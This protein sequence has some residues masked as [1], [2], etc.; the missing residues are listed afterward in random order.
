MEDNKCDYYFE[1][2]RCLYQTF[3]LGDMRRHLSKEAKCEWKNPYIQEGVF[4]EKY[5]N[6]MSLEKKY[7]NAEAVKKE[8]EEKKKEETEE[9]EAHENHQD[10]HFCGKKFSRKTNLKRHLQTSCT[11]KKILEFVDLEKAK[12]EIHNVQNSI[13]TQNNIQTQNITNITQNISVNIDENALKNMLIPFFEKFDTSH[14][15][16]DKRRKLLFKTVYQDALREILK[17]ESNMNFYISNCVKQ[18]SLIFK[19]DI[20]RNIQ[21][22]R[23]ELCEVIWTKIK[24]YFTELLEKFIEDVP[25]CN[26]KTIDIIRELI[27]EEFENQQ[28]N[29]II[30]KI[31]VENTKKIF[32]QLA[33]NLERIDSQSNL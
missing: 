15:S 7:R 26:S 16:E 21:I 10:C 23:D 5:I 2:R 17:N 24:N 19:N 8:F 32:Q 31:S 14:I 12:I 27:L 22:D 28:K 30:T 1:C 20:E 13:Q 29:E 11:T 4:E 3:R 18:K 9:K 6:E 25:E 33:K